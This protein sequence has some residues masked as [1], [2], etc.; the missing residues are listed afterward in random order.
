MLK[1]PYVPASIP[2]MILFLEV[3]APDLA[4]Q[5]VTPLVTQNSTSTRLR[6]LIP[7]KRPIIPPANMKFNILGLWRI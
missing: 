7:E 2:W 6:M 4:M 1:I 5:P 3:A